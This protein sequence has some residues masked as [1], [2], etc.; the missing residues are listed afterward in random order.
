M[1]DTELKVAFQAAQAAGK[2]LEYKFKQKRTIIKKG[3]IDLVTDAD[4]K[5]EKSIL[6]IIGKRFP[7]DNILSEEAGD[8]EKA[9]D[10]KWLIDPLDGTTNFAHGYACFAVSIAFE[11][12]GS[13]AFGIVYNPCTGEYFEAV[14]G[15]GCFL[16]KKKISVSKTEKIGDALLA[17]GF[18][19][20]VQENP[21]RPLALFN[22]MI[23]NAQ[24]VRRPGSAAI[25]L[26]YVAAGIFDGF[27][28]EK[29]KPWD[30]AAGI[31][32]AK[33]AGAVL[34]T[35]DGKPYT[36]Y[37]ETILAA[38]PFIYDAMLKLLET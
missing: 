25:D 12:Q 19:Y 26:C 2:I 11:V 35:Y 28:E 23:I 14:E 36:P 18:P 24:G 17:T 38:N 1:Y 27:W 7:E 5:S 29:L 16:N 13:V 10:R 15:G 21:Q 34:S 30:T 37:E 22:R 9:S 4:L 33:E 6:E 8:L 32:I 3:E 31:I 20:D